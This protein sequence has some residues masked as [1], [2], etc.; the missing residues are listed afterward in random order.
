MAQTALDLGAQVT[1]VSGP[2][3]LATL[4]GATRIVVTTGAE[5][6]EVL[7]AKCGA[8][9]VVIMAAPVADFRPSRCATGNIKKID[10]G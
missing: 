6:A 9:D 4:H 8:A 3:G 2:A 10:G 5:M 1:L 7:L